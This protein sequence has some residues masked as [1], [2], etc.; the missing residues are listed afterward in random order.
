MTPPRAGQARPP[1]RGGLRRW[2]ILA[3]ALVPFAAPVQDAPSHGNAWVEGLPAAGYSG[4]RMLVVEEDRRLVD[5]TVGH[6]DIARHHPLRPD[7]IYRIYSMT[8]PVVS[9]AVLRMVARGHADL[10]DPVALHLPELSG[11]AVLEADGRRRAPATMLTIRHLLTHTTGFP[12][13]AGPAFAL[14]EQAGL[15]TSTSLADYIARLAAVPLE[16]DP[17]T[18]FRYDSIATEVLGRLLE[19][20]S[21]QT[22][23][24]HLHEA[25]FVPL[26][27]VDTGFEVAPAQ[28]HRVVEPSRW[29]GGGL[30]AD[31]ARHARHPGTPLRPYPSAA[32]GLYS[33]AADYLAFARMLLDDGRVDGQPWLPAVLAVGMRRDALAPMGLAIP[34]V[35]E[36]PGQGFGLGLSVLLDPPARERLG[37]A[38]Q[39]GWSGAAST[40]FVIDPVRQRIGL[41]L[42]QHLRNGDD[43]DLPRVSTAFYNQVQQA[44]LP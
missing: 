13:H 44:T 5:A 39:A 41:L 3:L 32:G 16:I 25:V 38:G 15:E 30:I 2:L 4:A 40:Y 10:D 8:K 20:W 19:V 34:F 1:C 14:R 24:V 27:M 7:A 26:G 35:D 23:D 31:D 12:L 22:L 9:A 33:T 21:G 28:R 17:G 42:L 36:R 37:A 43:D 18:R 6:A 29:R 11:L